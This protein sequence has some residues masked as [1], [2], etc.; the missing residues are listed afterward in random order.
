M[1]EMQS[2]RP[3]S[4]VC[5]WCDRDAL[6]DELCV[7]QSQ[8]QQTQAQLAIYRDVVKTLDAVAGQILAETRRVDAVDPMMQEGR[9]KPC[10]D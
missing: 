6:M 8:L 2:V 4:A 3:G 10:Q 9:V 1:D 7:T 5:R